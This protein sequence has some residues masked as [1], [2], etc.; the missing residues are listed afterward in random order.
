MD[1]TRRS[2]LRL[3]AAGSCLGLASRHA[4]ASWLQPQ[5]TASGVTP[6]KI[7]ILGGTGFLGPHIVESARKRGHVLTLFNRGRTNPQLFP[8][9][10][11]LQ[12]DRDGKLQA[13]EG[14]SFDAVV[15]T[16]GHV[17][18]IVR[19][20]AELLRD[21]VQHYVFISSIGLY[22]R[23]LPGMDETAPV[24]TLEDESVEQI[25]ATTLGPL[26][27]LCERAAE[28]VMPGRVANLRAGWIVGPGDGLNHFTYWL[29]RIDR[30]GEVL[31]P[32]SPEDPVQF[33][34]ARDLADWIVRVVE[35][36]VVGI[37]NATGPG[38]RIGFV[39]LFEECKE[40]TG[41]RADLTWVDAAF[42]EKQKVRPLSDLPMWSPAGT[43]PG[44]VSVKKAIGKGLTFR[45]LATTIQDTLEWWKSLPK[46]RRIL[47]VGLDPVR[48]AQVLKAWHERG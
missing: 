18:R 8:D 11:K 44:D 3:A 14:R 36:R 13:L 39:D 38:E 48:E 35:D 26:K 28:H 24:R 23:S 46:A 32:G 29:V 33:I 2:F 15:D 42:L 21:S 10:E 30:G 47:S 19:A 41:S 22:A 16:S 31:A 34:D 6:K 25:T 45:P 43:Y 4:P 17:P 20:S 27:A 12:G 7:L 5:G 40:V 9:V 1:L 37:Y